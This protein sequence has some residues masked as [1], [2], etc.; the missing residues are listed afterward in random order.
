[1][2][3]NFVDSSKIDKRLQIG[4]WRA[5]QRRLLMLRWLRCY[6]CSTLYCY[7]CH[8]VFVVFEVVAPIYVGLYVNADQPPGPL[9]YCAVVSVY[10]MPSILGIA[11]FWMHTYIL[12]TFVLACLEIVDIS[13]SWLPTQ[14]CTVSHLYE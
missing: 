12:G 11:H 9:C 14:H 13:S 4:L 8:F 7:F 6:C 10:L 3:T 1:M 2:L 5:R